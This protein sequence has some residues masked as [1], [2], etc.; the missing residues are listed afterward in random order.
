[1][2]TLPDL[3]PVL[4][5]LLLAVGALVLL[6][7]GAFGGERATPVVTGMAAAGDRR[8]RRSC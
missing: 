8:W 2:A 6:M 1:M 4:P 7:V 3:M 5:E